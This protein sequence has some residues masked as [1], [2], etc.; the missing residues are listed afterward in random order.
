MP[1]VLFKVP[2]GVSFWDVPPDGKRFLMAAPSA[3]GPSMQPKFT[4]VL[5]WLSLLK[6]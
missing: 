6:K 4:V 2:L 3:E 5:N 1:K